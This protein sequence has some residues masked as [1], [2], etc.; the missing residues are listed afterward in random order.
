MSSTGI[1]QISHTFISQIGLLLLFLITDFF[2]FSISL[3]L[4]S[5]SQNRSYYTVSQ[6]KAQCFLV[7]L[8]HAMSRFPTAGKIS[9]VTETS[10]IIPFVTVLSGNF[11]LFHKAFRG[12]IL[13]IIHSSR[14]FVSE[15]RLTSCNFLNRI[16]F[17]FQLC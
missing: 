8:C 9:L 1:R 12:R 16:L 11:E 14:N 17:Q 6:S 5:H 7:T 3:L 4:L 2:G 13:A 10:Q 15:Q